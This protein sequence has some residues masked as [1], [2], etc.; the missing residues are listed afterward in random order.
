MGYVNST[1]NRDF[2]KAAQCRLQLAIS[3]YGVQKLGRVKIYL[4]PSTEVDLTRHCLNAK[5]TYSKMIPVI[6]YTDE[7]I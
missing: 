3:N 2:T 5:L 4:S 6:F 7:L 1:A